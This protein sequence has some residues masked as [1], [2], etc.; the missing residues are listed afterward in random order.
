LYKYVSCHFVF[1]R[2]YNVKAERTAYAYAYFFVKN[3]SSEAEHPKN[4]VIQIVR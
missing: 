4:L 3:M 1:W 2:Y